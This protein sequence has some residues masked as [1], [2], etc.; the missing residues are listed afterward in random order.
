MAALGFERE[1]R[2]RR[3]E[4]RAEAGLDPGAFP[5]VAA[6][7]APGERAEGRERAA[8][9]APALMFGLQRGRCAR[10]TC[11]SCPP[12][13]ERALPPVSSVTKPAS[14]SRARPSAPTSAKRLATAGGGKAHLQRLASRRTPSAGR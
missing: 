1:A 3:G 12:I 14:A 6:V 4:A 13:T 7:A 2:A 8:T 9:E 10:Q 5:P 11:T